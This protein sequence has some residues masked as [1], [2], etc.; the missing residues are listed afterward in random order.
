MP[1]RALSHLFTRERK[2]AHMPLRDAFALLKSLEPSLAEV[3]AESEI[4]LGGTYAH[5]DPL[6]RSDL[7]LNIAIHYLEAASD[8]SIDLDAPYFSAP[9]RR[10]VRTG[11]LIGRPKP[12]PGRA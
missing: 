9:R 12:P 10:E 8:P 6:L 4:P 7:A 2:L 11:M 1:E 5:D 3:D